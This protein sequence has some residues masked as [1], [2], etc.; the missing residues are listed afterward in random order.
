MHRI[1]TR[2]LVTIL[3]AA[4][5]PA[6]PMSVVVHD[7]LERSFN[8]ALQQT[9]TEGLTAALDGTRAELRR[10]MDVFVRDVD[11][12]WRPHTA[13]DPATAPGGLL[14]L[15]D[16][17][18]PVAD[19]PA[20]PALIAALGWLD[21]QPQVVDGYM[22]MKVRAGGG[23]PVV[24]A[25]ALPTG[26]T[27]RVGRIEEALGLLAVYRAERDAI[28]RSYLLPF[29][30]VYALLIAAVLAVA[31]LMARRL[32]A[33]LEAVSAAAARVAEGEL[34]TRVAARAPG[35][36]GALIE[37]FN[38]MVERLQAQRRELGR[39]E[40]MAA[41]RG[42]ARI[43]AHEIKN[44]LTPIL[45]AVQQTRQGY[46]GDDAEHRHALADCETIVSEE[47][48]GLRGLVRSFSEFARLPAPELGDEDPAGL[49]ESL[50]RLYG[51][52]LAVRIDGTLPTSWRCD[53]SQLR[54]ALVNLIDNG[55]G[56]CTRHGT[57]ARVD[58]TAACDGETLR[59]S[60]RDEGGGIPPA[61]RERIFEPDFSTGGQGMGLGLPITVGITEAHG[62]GVD[63][64]TVEGEGSVFTLHLP[65]LAD[66]VRT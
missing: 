23:R 39:L 54:R 7:L 17:G 10:H 53:A 64:E 58:L 62:G 61:L 13:L 56:A 29:L 47:V 40:K 4:L 1:R 51:E 27:A 14:L 44:P 43:L 2:L 42:M 6:L 32:A 57:T 31:L 48:D 22:A 21:D 66:E 9:L 30:I 41:W 12:V 52:Q 3:F 20:A 15:D 38:G 59:L 60:V 45:L 65:R 50:E 11:R 28:L 34:D 26:L 55:L 49:L 37:A 16:Q 5:L 36:I 33:P 18:D 8:P 46:R 19:P 35:E 25:R 63:L 24:A